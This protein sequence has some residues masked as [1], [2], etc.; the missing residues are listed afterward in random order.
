[1]RHKILTLALSTLIVLSFGVAANAATMNVEMTLTGSQVFA[2]TLTPGYQNDVGRTSTINLTWKA[3]SDFTVKGATLGFR[4]YSPDASIASVT[5]AGGTVV[6]DPVNWAPASVWDLGGGQ[7]TL[8]SFD[9][10]LPDSFLTGGAAIGGGFTAGVVFKNIV[11]ASATLPGVDGKLCIDTTFIPPA[12]SWVA[13]P[14][15]VKP[16]WGPYSPTGYCITT[17]DPPC[18]APSVTNSVAALGVSHCGVAAYDFDATEG[19]NV[20]SAGP[21]SW[22]ITSAPSCGVAVINSSTGAFT[23]TPNATCVGVA[24]SVT[25]TASNTCGG[26]TDVVVDL[27][28]TNVA[29][30]ITCP[31]AISIAKGNS[32]TTPPASKVDPDACDAWVYSLV[33]VLPAPIGTVSVNPATGAITFNADANDAGPGD[34][35]YV[36]CIAVSDGIASAQCCVTLTVLFTE[37]FCLRIGQNSEANSVFQGNFTEVCITYESGSNTVGG[38][39][40]LVAYDNS[41][42]S[43]TGVAEGNIYPDYAWEYFTYR[44]GANGNC[45]GGCPSGLVRIIGLAETNNGAAHPDS[46]NLAVGDTLACMTF[47]ISNNR[48]YECQFA[49]I[50][51]FWL[52]CGDNALSSYSGDTLYISSAVY[53]YVGT[54]AAGPN[55]DRSDITG[56]DPTFP[57]LTGATDACDVDGGP[58]KPAPIRFVCFLDGGIWIACADSIDARGDLNLNG[59][60]NEIADAVLYTQYFVQGLAAFNFNVE[61]QIAAS[62]VNG[63]GIPLSVADLVY[64]IRVIVGDAL[65]LP[66]SVATSALVLTSGSVISTNIELGAALFVFKGETSV[67][68]MQTNL[69]MKTGVRDGNTY[70]IVYPNFEDKASVSGIA[71]GAVVSANAELISVE[72]AD[73]AGNVVANKVVPG[74]FEL[75]QNYPN[76]FNPTTKIAFTT[77]VATSWTLTV[78]NIAG[79]KVSE[80]AGNT[81]SANKVVVDVNASDWASGVYFYKVSAGSFSATKKMALL[82]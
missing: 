9:G 64:L 68:L 28:A 13:A 23:W 61:G 46:E 56:L 7:L 60:A 45:N 34:V 50:R 20:P 1:M 36:V 55:F 72:M 19:G 74:A 24:V 77:P 75:A 67:E 59:L 44:F 21:V 53:D 2:N 3:K 11:T 49:P 18:I 76:P 62:E 5:W 66:K 16:S 51:F 40:L 22:S 63:D 69:G 73:L 12:G 79:Q 30:Q 35:P 52:D 41:V 48:N 15:G 43:L 58:G 47:L 70:A 57:T 31:P 17:F 26:S 82:K 6:M 81:A 39:D 8:R 71:A 54:G 32:G 42:L 25:V 29:P 80:Y 33:S 14:G 10:T 37:P 65:P 4:V 27:N 38:F 78:Y